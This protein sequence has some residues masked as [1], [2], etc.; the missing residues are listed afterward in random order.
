MKTDFSPSFNSV[1]C[2]L[3]FSPISVLEIWVILALIPGTILRPDEK[4]SKEI[5][6]IFRAEQYTDLKPPYND[7]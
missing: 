7:L 1:K 6:E 2:Q 4:Y 5:V 3:F